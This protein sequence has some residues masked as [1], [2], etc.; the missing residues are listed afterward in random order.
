VTEDLGYSLLEP[1]G[2]EGK[3]EQV[4]TGKVRDVRIDPGRIVRCHHHDGNPP[5]L[6]SQ[7]TDDAAGDGR[8]PEIEHQCVNTDVFAARKPL[9]QLVRSDLDQTVLGRRQRHRH[10]RVSRDER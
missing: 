1:L 2:V 4:D 10:G 8:R 6:G 3:R 5:A 9:V 7:V